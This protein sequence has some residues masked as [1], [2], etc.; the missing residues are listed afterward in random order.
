MNPSTGER[1]R[2]QHAKRALALVFILVVT[3]GCSTKVN[4]INN[5]NPAPSAVIT[6]VGSKPTSGAGTSSVA[7]TVRSGSVV[8]LS[9]KDSNGSGVALASFH[10]TQTGG[11]SL[12][13]A[14]DVG[15]MLYQTSN[16]VE[17]TAPQVSSDTDFT[18][19]L[20]V[21]NALNVSSTATAT[22]TVTAAN[23]P[24]E[25]LIPD[26]V[27]NSAPPRRFVVALAPSQKLTLSSDNAVCVKVNRLLSYKSRDGTVH[28]GAQMLKLPALATLQANATW[29]QSVGATAPLSSSMGDVAAALQ[30]TA[31]PRVVFDVP[32]F[33]DVELQA[34]FNQPSFNGDMSA[35]VSS[36]NINSQLVSSDLDSVQ[37]Y[38]SI[39]ATPGSCDGNAGAPDLENA[40]LLLGAFAPGSTS[41]ALTS[42]SPWQLTADALATAVSPMSSTTATPTAETLAGAQ[43]YYAAIDPPWSGVTQ[44]AT[45]S[46]LNTWLDDNCFDHTQSDYGTGAAAANGAHAVYTN[47]FD[48]GFGRDMYFIR[49]TRDHTD[50]NGNVTAHAGDMA[51]VVI[52]YASLEQTAL[53]QSPIIAVAM[54]YQGPGHTNGNCSSSATTGST[55]NQCFTKFYVFAPDDRTGLFERVSSANFDRRGEKYVPGACISCHGG[56]IQNAQFI[57]TQPQQNP[58]ENVDAAFMPWDLDALL[59]SDT[60]PAFSKALVDGQPAIANPAP[61]TRLAQ[62]SNLLKLNALAWQT[63]QVP[64]LLSTAGGSCSTA[65]ATC[66]DRFAAPKALLSKWYGW[67]VAQGAAG[68]SCAG[69]HNYTD[70]AAPTVTA[71][72]TDWPTGALPSASPNPDGAPNDLYHDVYAHHCRSCHTMSNVF[73]NQFNDF[74]DFESHINPAATHPLNTNSLQRLLYL[75]AQMPLA[76]L[77]M[78]RFWVDFNGGATSAAQLLGAYINSDKAN[79]QVGSG[80]GTSTVTP[81]GAPVLVASIDSYNPNPIDST[82]YEP[83]APSTAQPVARFYGARVDFSASLFVSSY[84]TKLCLSQTADPSSCTPAADQPVVIGANN[85]SPAFDTSTAGYYNLTVDATSAS[86]KTAQALFIPDVNPEPPIISPGCPAAL[87]GTEGVPIVANLY[88]QNGAAVCITPGFE[89]SGQFNVLQIN[90]PSTVNNSASGWGTAVSGSGWAATVSNNNQVTLTFNSQATAGET[91]ALAYR[92]TDVDGSNP[93]GSITFS[94]VDTLTANNQTIQVYPSTFP[95]FVAPPYAIPASELSVVIPLPE[96][97]SDVALVLDSGALTSM[98]GTIAAASSPNLASTGSFTYTPT[99]PSHTTFLTCDVNGMDLVTGSVPCTN[100]DTFT[101]H[102]LSDSTSQTSSEATVNLNVQ[103]TT[104]F[105]RTT[106]AGRLNTVADI[107]SILTA[108]GAGSQPCSNCHVNGIAAGTFWIYTAGSPPSTWTSITGG[109]TTGNDWTTKVLTNASGAGSPSTGCLHHANGYSMCA[110]LYDNV[111]SASNHSTANDSLSPANCAIL[112]QWILE[113]A[114]ND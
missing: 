19:Q 27:D 67:C 94:V 18:F 33:N 25:F 74:A 97:P 68:T 44:G 24:N 15:A 39:S 84:Q 8:I 37:L 90:Y 13:A 40:S 20:T 49:C 99:P 104:S 111:C 17:F 113:G 21:T 69:A 103:A 61:Y 73:S 58:S 56:K 100:F 53:K 28:D 60:D 83:L 54:E 63:Y 81:P 43:A 85:A 36:G 3:A 109:N 77:T 87:S 88:G 32:T 82:Q 35:G 101:Y 10:F 38:L 1:I 11:P 76:R 93:L 5:G 52:N 4:E 41:A 79:T 9:G 86:G 91:V 6:P 46:D 75:S 55:A 72:G 47:N 26:V 65:S 31:N 64:E 42:T 71:G 51:A 66:I 50:A 45:K 112:L 34:M 114:H 108:P 106:S 89:P 57:D 7:I 96:T 59:Y 16:T 98:G 48:L 12:A 29:L 2:G 92:V 102:L 23:D 70:T 110:A 107:Y 95:P 80:A 30:S 105:A 14:P 22:V 78:D 62:E